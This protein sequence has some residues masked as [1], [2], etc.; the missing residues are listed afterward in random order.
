MTPSLGVNRIS[1]VSLTAGVPDVAYS[2]HSA[3]RLLQLFDL[4][5]DAMA[6][7]GF[8]GYFKT[9]NPAWS[10][11]LGF[12]SEELLSCPYIE[13][14]HPDDRRD[15]VDATAGLA[16]GSELIKFECRYL[17]QDGS[18]KWLSSSSIACLDEE[19]IYTVA[20]DVTF[21]HNCVRLERA[22]AA[23]T[24]VVVA[25]GHW[26]G[27]ISG[28]LAA[29]CTE[30]QW[31]SG[32]YWRVDDKVLHVARTWA[33]AA[34]GG[35]STG[36]S[37]PGAALR[38]N[39]PIVLDGGAELAR[40][41]APGP[42]FGTEYG[43]VGCPVP[44]PAGGRAAL[45]FLTPT[46]YA[47]E[48][49][50]VELLGRVAERLGEFAER[51]D[52]EQLDPL[53]LTSG[54]ATLEYR[55]THDSLTS[56]ANRELTNDRIRT[57]IHAARRTRTEIAVMMVD[58]NDF[59]A[60]N[61]TRGHEFGDDVLRAVAD[62]LQATVRESDAVGRIG[63]DEFAIVVGGRINAARATALAAKICR[64]FK[65]PL[66]NCE[67]AVVGL[68]VGVAMYPAHGDD[69]A[70]LL[71]SADAAMYAAKELPDCWRLYEPSMRPGRGPSK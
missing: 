2:E 50:L 68:S 6:V 8:D 48:E 66:A 29:L 32:E 33:G 64:A 34:S 22:Q 13:F 36:D 43:A 67:G 58:L 57:A 10:A 70:Q 21:E 26:D 31:L 4:S 45:S 7:V 16:D 30:M 65:S 3:H 37:V 44:T 54:P 41:H 25:S 20:R 9:I 15:T 53:S 61:D 69:P 17:C 52:Q 63:G 19:V 46:H 1:E 71:R 59:K 24:T 28:V 38:N 12:S 56:L 39:V 42:E 47:P 35:L 51:L 40:P 55:A 18:Y 62:R 60:I 14:V 23:V 11:L 27:A 49:G 5:V